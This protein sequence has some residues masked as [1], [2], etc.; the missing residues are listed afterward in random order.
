VGEDQDRCLEFGRNLS[1]D[2][3]PVKA[4]LHDE[5]VVG[6]SAIDVDRRV[7]LFF[8]YTYHCLGERQRN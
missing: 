7:I 8:P 5:L 4:R 2:T 3:L 6:D 1:P